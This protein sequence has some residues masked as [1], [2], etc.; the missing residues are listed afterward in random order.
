MHVGQLN[1]RPDRH[2]DAGSMFDALPVSNNPS[3]RFNSAAL[4]GTAARHQCAAKDDDR[5]IYFS[6]TLL[7]ARWRFAAPS[8]RAQAPT[9]TPI[10]RVQGISHRRTLPKIKCRGKVVNQAPLILGPLSAVA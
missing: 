9:V 8:R 2:S 3:R 6:T 1:H 7:K 5:K 4:S 10:Q